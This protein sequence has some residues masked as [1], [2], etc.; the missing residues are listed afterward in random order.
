MSR[1]DVEY[2]LAQ[3]SIAELRAHYLAR[4]LSVEDAVRWYLARI[5]AI[6]ESGPTINAVRER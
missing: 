1:M 4:R 2:C 6:S 3:G 5:S